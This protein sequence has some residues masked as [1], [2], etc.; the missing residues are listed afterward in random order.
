MPL[1]SRAPA[2]SHKQISQISRSASQLHD[3]NAFTSLAAQKSASATHTPVHVIE[4]SLV[5]R[6][7]PTVTSLGRQYELDNLHE[8]PSSQS[9]SYVQLALAVV[10]EV[11]VVV[12]SVVD[13]D[14]VVAAVVVV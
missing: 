3:R 14:V 1:Q 6:E 12:S 11:D 5:L 8:Y 7:L 2:A 9:L 10:D 13:V 4:P